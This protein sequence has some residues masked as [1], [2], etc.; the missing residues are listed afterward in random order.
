MTSKVTFLNEAYG[1]YYHREVPEPDYELTAVGP[2]TPCGEYMR[3]FWHPVAVAEDLKEFPKAVRILG[4]DLVVFR[5]G[6]GQLGLLELHCAHRASSLEFGLIEERGIRCC[7]HGWTFDVDG[8]ILK[9][10]GVEGTLKDRLYQGAYPVVEKYGLV[11]AYMGPPD[12]KPEF[13]ESATFNLPG[14]QY[15]APNEIIWPCNWLQMKDN[16]VDPAHAAIL[17]SYE[18]MLGV[19]GFSPAFADFGVMDWMETPYGM[20]YISTR[21]V[22]NNIWVRLGEYVLPDGMFIPTTMEMGKEIHPTNYIAGATW[23]V[24]IDDENTL[25]ITMGLIPDN[26]EKYQTRNY[27]QDGD[28]PYE[29]KQQIPADFDAQV[30]QRRINVHAMERLVS[31]DKGVIM[32]R[33]QV[34]DGIRAVQRGEDPQGIVRE[35]YTIVPTYASNTV[36]DIPPA[37]TPEE[38]D[39]LVFNTGRRV[40]AEI[41]ES[42]GSHKQLDG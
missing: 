26:V 38:D 4:E 19:G 11:F 42:G 16:N 23:M 18:T 29:L 25:R 33:N 41:I 22:D 37:A 27:G 5:D 21:R 39:L 40:A 2:G 13:P 1:A 30:S 24:P 3:R 15:G 35:P 6:S 17:H 31:T 7:Y 34:R 20:V 28:R 36:V 32:L 12:K 9:M 14:Y 8:K 10:P